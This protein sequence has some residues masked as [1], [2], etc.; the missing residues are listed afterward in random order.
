MT[1]KISYVS[2]L[3]DLK[4]SSSP[5]MEIQ[6]MSETLDLILHCWDWSAKKI[7]SSVLFFLSMCCGDHFFLALCYII[8]EVLETIKLV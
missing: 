3:V 6:V 1:D 4:F 7:L 5:M 2:S 8:C